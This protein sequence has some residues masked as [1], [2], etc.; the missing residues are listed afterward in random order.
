MPEE[1]VQEEPPG[2]LVL[3]KEPSLEPLLSVE[4]EPQFLF[5]P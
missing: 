3:K 5:S 2:L 1:L 4:Q